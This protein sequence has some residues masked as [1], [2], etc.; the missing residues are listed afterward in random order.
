V[1]PEPDLRALMLSARMLVGTTPCGASLAEAH[2][3]ARQ[4][5]EEFEWAYQRAMGRVPTV[6]DRIS[7]GVL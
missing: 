3:R 6:W 4:L 2:W 5:S 7:R 1:N